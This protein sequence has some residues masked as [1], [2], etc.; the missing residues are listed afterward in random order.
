MLHPALRSLRRNPLLRLASLWLVVLT[1]NVRGLAA[2]EPAE[3]E[4]IGLEFALYFSPTPAADPEKELRRLL[5]EPARRLRSREGAGPDDALALV[6]SKWTPLADYAPPTAESMRYFGQGVTP[7]EAPALAQAERVFIIGVVAPRTHILLA[8]RATAQLLADLATVT[9]GKIWDEETRQ[10]FSPAR[11]QADR[12]DS[13]QGGIPNVTKHVTMHAYANPELVRIITLGL[14]KFGVPDLVVSDVPSQQSRPVGNFINAFMQRLVEGQKPEQGKMLLTL[15][16]IR[17]TAVRELSLA[18]PG[19]GAKGAVLVSVAAVPL[20]EGDPINLLWN[21]DF[22][23]A[24]LKQTTE[25]TMWGMDQLFGSTDSIVQA[26][27][28]DTQL[29]EASARARESLFAREAFFRAGLPFK[30]HL[31]VKAPFQE[32]EHTEYMWVEV[33]KWREAAVEGVLTSDPYYVKKIHPGS[34]VTVPFA[35][36]YDYIYYK[37]DGSREGNETGKI[38][39]QMQP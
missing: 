9:A 32:G 1:G 24:K 33:V 29:A 31:L 5:A 7:E 25:R 39:E 36:I 28:G 30:E 13:W 6:E 15:S 37:A 20:E 26:K 35:D 17:H 38:L 12:L 11:W 27:R 23:D 34:K 3:A 8:N 22:P 16:G 19:P 10:L 18:N 14:R 2:G 21:L 4:A